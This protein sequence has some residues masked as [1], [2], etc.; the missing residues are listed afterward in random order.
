MWRLVRHGKQS[1]FDPGVPLAIW[2]QPFNECTL[3]SVLPGKNCPYAFKK[4]IVFQIDRQSLFRWQSV[5]HW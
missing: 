2:R 5:W 1:N 3:N 4:M